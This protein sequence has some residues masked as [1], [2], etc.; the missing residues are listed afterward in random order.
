MIRQFGERGLAQDTEIEEIL[1]TMPD[2][3][4]WDKIMLRQ[5]SSFPGS[6]DTDPH[7]SGVTEPE[8]EL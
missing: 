7:S 1:S 4:S 6:R 5:V 2:R 8:T 3:Q